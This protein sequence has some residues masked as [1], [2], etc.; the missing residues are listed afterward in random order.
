MKHLDISLA[1]SGLLDESFS[2]FS[3]NDVIS[4]RSQIAS[5]SKQISDL[6]SDL[7]GGQHVPIGVVKQIESQLDALRPQLADLKNQLSKIPKAITDAVDVTNTLNTQLGTATSTTVDATELLA[8]A[9]Q[10]KAIQ[11][12]IDK[13]KALQ[14]K[15][16][17]VPDKKETLPNSSPDSY[18]A[19]VADN[20]VFTTKNI[21]IGVSI[22]GTIVGVILLVKH[23]K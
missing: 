23:F 22:I 21:V 14:D 12:E 8:I 11:A 20:S 7:N 10:N 18:I 19:P 17:G 13:Q 15:L 9:N 6:E 3:A 4:L 1:N 5:V 16:N 2:N